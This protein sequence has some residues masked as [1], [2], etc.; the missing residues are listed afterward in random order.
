MFDQVSEKA[1][2]QVLRI[3]HGIAAAAHETVKRRPIGLAKLCKRGLRNLRV[4]L[5]SP[6]RENHAPVGRRK[7]IA[8]TVPV[9]CQGFH[10]SGLYQDRR[11]KASREKNYDSV[12]HALQNPFVKG[13]QNEEEKGHLN[14]N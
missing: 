8:L 7:Q 1:L 9:P 4:G 14:T 3:V 13:N 10:V 5:A 2:R 11:R 6:S 12:Q